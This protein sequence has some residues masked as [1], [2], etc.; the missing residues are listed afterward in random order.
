MAPQCVDIHIF[1]YPQ[2]SAQDQLKGVPSASKKTNW[3]ENMGFTV[4]PCASNS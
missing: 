4:N 2:S 3:Q 1:Q